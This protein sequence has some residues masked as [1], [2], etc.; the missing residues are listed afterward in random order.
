[1]RNVAGIWCTVCDK[2]ANASFLD[3]PELPEDYAGA[4]VEVRADCGHLYDVVTQLSRIE[5][6][7]GERN[8]EARTAI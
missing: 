3:V 4:P 2:L 6:S 5:P 1:V 8:S 7:P